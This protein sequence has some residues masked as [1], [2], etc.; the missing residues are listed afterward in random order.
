VLAGSVPAIWGDINCDD[1][2]NNVDTLAILRSRMNFPGYPEGVCW[3]RLTDVGHTV[4]IDGTPR[5]WGDVDC[6]EAVNAVD[7][8]KVMRHVAG[9]PVAQNEPCPDLGTIVEFNR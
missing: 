1:Q 5:V 2:L 6:S 4:M 7:A 9:L 3:T 8:L